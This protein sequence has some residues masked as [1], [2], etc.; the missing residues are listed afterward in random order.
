MEVREK[1]LGDGGKY[2]HLDPNFIV[3]RGTQI[4]SSTH[5]KIECVHRCELFGPWRA[6]GEVSVRIRE[7]PRPF[8]GDI[9]C[10]LPSTEAR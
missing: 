5:N 10:G 7:G 1:Y 2:P 3:A 4:T 8:Y 9:L 6:H